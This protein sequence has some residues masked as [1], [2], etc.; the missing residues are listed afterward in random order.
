MRVNP[1]R[2][3]LIAQTNRVKVNSSISKA[4]IKTHKTIHNPC[5]C[6]GESV[7]SVSQRANQS[8]ENHFQK[9]QD[10]HKRVKIPKAPGSKPANP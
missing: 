4:K 7:L 6:L 8:P 9:A 2:S 10:A 1:F 3:G 5:L